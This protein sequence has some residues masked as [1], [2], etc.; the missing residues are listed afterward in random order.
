MS[1]PGTG[2]WREMMACPGKVQVGRI[3]TLHGEYIFLI[4]GMLV[5]QN[6]PFELDAERI[7]DQMYRYSCLVCNRGVRL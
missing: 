7:T 6:S 5:D 3:A 1:I 4:G 2:I